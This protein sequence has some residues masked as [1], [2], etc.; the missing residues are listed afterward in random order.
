ML[1]EPRGSAPWHAGAAGRDARLGSVVPVVRVLVVVLVVIRVE[2]LEEKGAGEGGRDAPEERGENVEPKSPNS[3]ATSIG[4]KERAG[5][6]PPPVK[7]PPMNTAAASA[8]P[9]ATAAMRELG[10]RG[11]LA[12]ST[13]TNTRMN[14]IKASTTNAWPVLT[15]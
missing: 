12:T 7:G 6:A 4:P 9:T 3:P 13:T 8:N 10:T 5:L 14:V 11:S 15:P 1:P 2:R